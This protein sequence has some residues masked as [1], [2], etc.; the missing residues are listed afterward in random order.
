[1]P[2]V[3]LKGLSRRY[4]DVAAVDDLSLEVKPGELVALLGPSGCRKTTTNGWRP[5]CCAGR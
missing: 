3:S 5:G 4:G 1:V 2:G